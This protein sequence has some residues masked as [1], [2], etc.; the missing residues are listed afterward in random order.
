[1]FNTGAE[2]CEE[3]TFKTN[4]VCKLIKNIIVKVYTCII[5]INLLILYNIVLSVYFVVGTVDHHYNSGIRTSYFR[6]PSGVC[7]SSNLRPSN[8]K[9][10]CSI[11]DFI[12]TIDFQRS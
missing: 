6:N 11:D 1:M 2:T 7:S 10:N 4:G 9:H 8:S 3:R 12:Y 5:I